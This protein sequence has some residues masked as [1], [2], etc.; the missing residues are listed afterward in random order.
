MVDSGVYNHEDNNEH[1]QG[2]I[3][4][5]EIRKMPDGSKLLGLLQ[6][7]GNKELKADVKADA[8]E[9]CDNDANVDAVGRN[10]DLDVSDNDDAAEDEVT[11]LSVATVLAIGR[12]AVL[13]DRSQ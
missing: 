13:P 1:E 12:R 3:H 11:R 2:H 10:Q 5:W 6:Y 9:Y 4:C 7:L 8:C